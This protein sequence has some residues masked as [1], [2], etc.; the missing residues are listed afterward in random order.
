MIDLLQ[1]ILA[2]M[3]VNIGGACSNISV[4]IG[5]VGVSYSLTNVQVIIFAVLAAVF[6]HQIPSQIEIL[7]AL[8][9]IIGS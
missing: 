1:M 7:A 5:T 3:I 9:G 2:G 6:L 4:S 8:L